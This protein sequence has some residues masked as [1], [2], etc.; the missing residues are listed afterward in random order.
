MMPLLREIASTALQLVLFTLIPFLFF[1]FRKDKSISFT[2]YIGLY[3]PTGAS[4]VYV[5]AAN[6]TIRLYNW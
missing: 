1:L 3:A 6:R 5:V 2:R 4:I